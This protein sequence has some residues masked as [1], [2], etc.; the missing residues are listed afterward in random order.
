ME[1]KL[2]PTTN[3]LQ[4]QPLTP[5]WRFSPWHEGK[6]STLYDSYEF[7]AVTKQ[8]NQVLQGTEITKTPC[9]S[10]IRSSYPLRRCLSRLYKE[11]AK[12]PRQVTCPV[13]NASQLQRQTCNRKGRRSIIPRLW[14]QLRKNFLRSNEV[15]I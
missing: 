3:H 15:K 13:V 11:N 2:P 8:L 6:G 5:S 9:P 14:K 4:A 10:Y 12:A 1:N 7:R